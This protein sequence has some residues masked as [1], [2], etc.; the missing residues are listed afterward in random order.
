M[1]ERIFLTVFLL[2]FF[3]S[4]DNLIDQTK[5]AKSEAKTLELEKKV[6]IIFFS[7]SFILPL[8]YWLLVCSQQI[9]T[10]SVFKYLHF[11]LKKNTLFFIPFLVLIAV[12]FLFSSLFFLGASFLWYSWP[13]I[14]KYVKRRSIYKYARGIFPWLSPRHDK[15]QVCIDIVFV[16]RSTFFFFKFCSNNG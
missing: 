14:Y 1:Q 4:V 11:F 2:R 5:V 6:T 12:F 7:L 13:T 8:F 15:N 3:F 9:T 16:F 10:F